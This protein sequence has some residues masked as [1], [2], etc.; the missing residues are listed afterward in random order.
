MSSRLHQ[1]LHNFEL[2]YWYKILYFPCDQ[3]RREG[4]SLGGTVRIYVIAVHVT[5]FSSL[6]C[7]S[8]SV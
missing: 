7:V 1:V 2:S 6:N 4:N 5:V 3:E 8:V